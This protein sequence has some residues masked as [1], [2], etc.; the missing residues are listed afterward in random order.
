MALKIDS[1]AAARRLARAILADIRLYE[2]EKVRAG[3]DL[4]ESIEEGRRLFRER[5][6][7]RLYDRF[8]A[9]VAELLPEAA[10]AVSS[11]AAVTRQAP[12]ARP[13]IPE[14]FFREEASDPGQRGRGLPGVLFLSLGLM[15]L[16]LIA[17]WLARG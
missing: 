3:E 17:F 6:E 16:G 8:E 10:A 5:V 1:E 13:G 14:S 15:I 4:S 9:A 7:A 2:S 12:E 11:T